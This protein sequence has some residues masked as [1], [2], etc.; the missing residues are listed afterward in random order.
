LHAAKL[1]FRDGS[2]GGST[3][4]FERTPTVPGMSIGA[5]LGEAWDLY[6]RFLWQF[7]LT[8]VVVFTV[9]DLLSAL[10][11]WGAGDSVSAG[12][13]WGVVSAVIGVV[14]YFWVQAA[15]VELVRDV[16]DGRADRTVAGTYRAVQ[17]RLG[18]VIAP[19][20]SPRSESGSASCS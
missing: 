2:C 5:V 7:F 1:V 4:L 14:G 10:A 12:V 11:E 8:A 18:A 13:F 17:P 16:R 20:S 3:R 19:A 6:R 15:L 9:L